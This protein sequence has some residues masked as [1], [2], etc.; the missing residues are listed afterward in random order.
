VQGTD[1]FQVWCADDRVRRTALLQRAALYLRSR[2]RNERDDVTR[3]IARFGRQLALGEVDIPGL[4]Q[5]ALR[6][7]EHDLAIELNRL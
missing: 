7:G 6:A 3:R 2:T 1:F 4:R 5:M